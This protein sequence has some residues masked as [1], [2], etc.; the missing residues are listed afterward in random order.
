[1]FQSCSLKVSVTGHPILSVYP[2]FNAY[3]SYFKLS[4]VPRLGKCK[5]LRYDKLF[6]RYI[7]DENDS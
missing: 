6:L 7:I 1:M 5:K 3:L 2:S 4:F